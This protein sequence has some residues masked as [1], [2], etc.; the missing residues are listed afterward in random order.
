MGKFIKENLPEPLDY[1]QSEGLKLSARGNWRTAEC[2]F[3]GSSVLIPCESTS[4][5]AH[6]F[7]WRAV[8]H[9]VETCWLIT[10]PRMAWT[11]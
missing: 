10:W 7:A 4:N 6:G 2:N 5:Q 9:A 8:V 1:F 3:H 11:S